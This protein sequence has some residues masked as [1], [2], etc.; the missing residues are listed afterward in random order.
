MLRYYML[1]HTFPPCNFLALRRYP[2]E[3]TTVGGGTVT[4]QNLQSKILVSPLCSK[5]W[6]YGGGGGGV[7][8]ESG[9]AKHRQRSKECRGPG[10]PRQEVPRTPSTPGVARTFTAAL[11]PLLLLLLWW[12]L[13]LESDAFLSLQQLQRATTTTRARGMFRFLRRPTR[14]ALDSRRAAL[15]LK[16]HGGGDNSKAAV[17]SR[18]MATQSDSNAKRSTKGALLTLED[19]TKIKG[20]SFGAHESVAGEVVFSTGMVGYPESLTDPS[21]KGQVCVREREL[22]L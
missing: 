20:Y 5:K 17:A 11:L 10:E 13:I 4:F 19:G 7:R 8:Q 22:R 12:L 2:G 14:Q 3:T 16:Q 21:Y 1:Y 15:S 9:N 6:M 18:F